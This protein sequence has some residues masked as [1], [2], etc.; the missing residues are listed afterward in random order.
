MPWLQHTC[1][2]QIL[3][4]VHAGGRSNACGIFGTSPASRVASMHRL[5]T[6]LDRDYEIFAF[7]HNP[8]PLRTVRMLCGEWALRR[9]RP[10]H[11]H[12]QRVRDING[13]TA[14]V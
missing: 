5:F 14:W 13:P 8:F 7:E 4:E 9:R 10:C 1:T 2:E 12:R 6:M 11:R 3:I